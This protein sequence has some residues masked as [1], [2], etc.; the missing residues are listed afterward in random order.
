SSEG[1]SKNT[2]CAPSGICGLDARCHDTND[3]GVKIVTGDAAAPVHCSSDGSDLVA[4]GTYEADFPSC[5]EPI[6]HIL[7][8]A[9]TCAICVEV[10]GNHN[11]TTSMQWRSAW[12]ADHSKI[13][14]AYIENGV[15]QT[16]GVE[17]WV[18][19][20]VRSSTRHPLDS[21]STARRTRA[22]ATFRRSL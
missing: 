5:C 11:P 4:A 22:T 3:G 7:L 6:M 20:T 15:A 17:E 16:G 13:V 21:A 1:C 12:N 10:D 19:P 8:P 18:S 9:P 2:D 14:I